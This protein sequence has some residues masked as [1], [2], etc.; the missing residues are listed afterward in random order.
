MLFPELGREPQSTIVIFLQLPL[1]TPKSPPRLFQLLMVL[2]LTTIPPASFPF[3]L[4]LLR[5]QVS[6]QALTGLLSTAS[7]QPL[8]LLLQLLEPVSTFLLLLRPGPGTFQP[9]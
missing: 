8:L 5:N 2:S 9:I 4:P 7:R 3:L 6:Y 1:G